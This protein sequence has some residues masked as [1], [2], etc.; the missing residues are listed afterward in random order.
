MRVMHR[1]IPLL[2]ALLLVALPMQ[3]ALAQNAGQTKIIERITAVYGTSASDLEA[4]R[5]DGLGW[6]EI[7]MVLE[8][9]RLS[10]MSAA[11]IQA[12]HAGGKGFGQIAKD[13]GI[14]PGEV[15]RA[16]AAVMSEGRARGGQGAA[17][18]AGQGK[19]HGKP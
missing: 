2:L 4:M 17:Q 8:L 18:G 16:V 19:G 13:L 14:N 9:A 11:D 12:M 5:A 7:I 10:G 15:G 3:A 6:G 1:V